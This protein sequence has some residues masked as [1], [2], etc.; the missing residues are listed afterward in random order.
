MKILAVDVVNLFLSRLRDKRIF[1]NKTVDKTK[2][3]HTCLQGLKPYEFTA[4]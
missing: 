3:L 4:C 1:V 2:T